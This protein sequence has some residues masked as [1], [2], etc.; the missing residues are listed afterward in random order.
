MSKGK[1]IRSKE[2]PNRDPDVAQFSYDEFFNNK[3]SLPQ[4]VKDH[5]GEKGLDW[6]FIN[7]GQFRSSGNTHRSHWKPHIFDQVEFG[8][9]AEGHITR[10]DLILATRPKAVS[11]GHRKFLKERNNRLNAFNRTKAQELKASM[12]EAGVK[13]K[14]TEGYEEN[15]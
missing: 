11:A 4:N 8:Q 7:A 5:L 10:G 9:S 6:R 3:L 1:E 13:G 2:I 15:E 14:V 12:A